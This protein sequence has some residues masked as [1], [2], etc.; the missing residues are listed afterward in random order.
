M[1]FLSLT[2]VSPQTS[3]FPLLSLSFATGPTL[4]G[5]QQG[6]A[7]NRAKISEAKPETCLVQRGVFTDTFHSEFRQGARLRKRKNPWGSQLTKETYHSRKITKVLFPQLHQ[8]IYHHFHDK[9]IDVS[10]ISGPFVQRAVQ[11]NF[12]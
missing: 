6:C 7:T 5:Y 2:N 10:S 9:A 8:P 12:F 3:R 4:I 1:Y 11:R